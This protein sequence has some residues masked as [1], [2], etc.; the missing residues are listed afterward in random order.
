MSLSLEACIHIVRSL[1][2]KEDLALLCRVS[3]V[4]RNAAERVLYNT[5]PSKTGYFVNTGQHY[6]IPNLPRLAVPPTIHV[7]SWSKRIDSYV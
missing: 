1:G 4:F 5:V 3:R 7:I 2:A 6:I